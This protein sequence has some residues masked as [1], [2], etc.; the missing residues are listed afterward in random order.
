MS[1]SSQRDFGGTERFSVERCLGAGAFGVVYQAFDRERN[2]RL[3]LKSLRQA[4]AA[5]LYRFK[6]EFRALADL[7]HRNLVTLY[8]LLSDGE[9]WFFTMELV[10][11]VSFLDYVRED[12][13][14]G[15]LDDS[16]P[17]MPAVDME[18][19]REAT[20]IQESRDSEAQSQSPDALS[21]LPPGPD[22]LERLRAALRQLA[23]GVSALHE[24]GIL[25]C[26]IKPSNVL[27]TGEGRVVL[28]D[29]G[30]VTE[31]APQE[32]RQS[33]H[34]VGTPAY[35]SPE[36]A[37][38]LAVSEATDWYSVGV[39]VYEALSG[40]LPFPGR[41]LEALMDKQRMEPPAPSKLVP[42]VPEDL[43]A[44]C[45]GLLRRDAR[46]RP[47]G[48]EVLHRLKGIPV[49][50][51]RSVPALP[52]PKRMRVFVGRD[53]HLAALSKA[54]EAAKQG[55]AVTVYVHGGSGMGKT[56][57]VRQFLERLHQVEKGVVVL[58]GRCYERESVPY[59]ALDSLV[60]ELSLYLKRLPTPSVEAL[61]PR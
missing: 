20:E 39:M 24:A 21:G 19:R 56:A 28:L 7:S 9:Q 1:S 31:L 60:D 16:S 23:E 29:F 45:Q 54:F 61:L 52:S 37:A 51:P 34:I 41:S 57:L 17:T 40:R 6:R 55:R 10:E 48:P 12:L 53:P 33:F 49:M 11:G 3:A 25:H 38:G 18:K 46:K 58:A 5:A 59:K 35:M 30:L 32:Y 44:L 26:D 43:N 27:V 8:E 15:S 50:T 22:S 47:S 42:E 13:R 2:T 36:Q 4:D 14:V